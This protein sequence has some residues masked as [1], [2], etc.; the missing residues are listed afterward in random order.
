MSGDGDKLRGA[1]GDLN[2]V[3]QRLM[4]KAND[5]GS[6]IA[7]KREQLARAEKSRRVSDHAIVRYL[8]RI[9]GIDMEKTRADMRDLCDASV[10][11]ANCD[12]LWH[13]RGMVFIT[14]DDGDVVTVLGEKE[15]E[16]YVP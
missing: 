15:V 13:S 2:A 8:E 10:S 3:R 6:D 4:S 14:N 16:G 12:G 9:Y 5:I 11:F 7:S 1:I